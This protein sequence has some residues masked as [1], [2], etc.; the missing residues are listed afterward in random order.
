ME[1][2]LAAAARFLA[3]LSPDTHYTFQ[4]FDDAKRGRNGMTRVLHGT[5]AAQS[6]RLVA[7]NDKGAGVFVMVNRGDGNGRRANNVTG[8]RALFLDLDGSPIEPVLAAPIPPRITVESSPG[9]WHAYWPVADLPPEQF[10]AAQK[11]LAG[12]F[13]GDPKVHDKPRVM[14]LPGFLHRKGDPFLSRLVDCDDRPVTWQEM[15]DAFG[16]A[17]R[18]TLPAA[19]PEG[20]RNA[21]L[22]KLAR[23][24]AAKGVSEADELAKLRKVNAERCVP[25]LPDAEVAQIVTSGYRSAADGLAAIPIAALDSDAYKALDDAG[26]TLLLL[27][28]RRA[29]KFW[30]FPLP[31]SELRDWFPREKTFNHVRRR[32]VE[33]GLLQVATGAEKAMPRK[34]R[35]PKPAFYRLAIGPFG[36][37]Y[38][39]PLIGPFGVPPEA[40]QAVAVEAVEG[41]EPIERRETVSKPSGKPIG[42]Q[43]GAR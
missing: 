6:R 9:R 41:G 32:V 13:A 12:M 30:A 39:N 10:T 8:C 15:A 34:Q 26:R 43:A 27:A 17:Q 23:S 28:Y 1:I 19:I 21:L 18:M 42:F 3:A 16:L 24:A 20:E 14:R 4:T 31:W 2:D 29:D 22:F 36:V 35:G 40:L 11:A 7:L 5:L 33:S 25:P 38:S 37:P